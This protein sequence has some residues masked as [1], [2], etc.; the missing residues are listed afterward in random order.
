MCEEVFGS[1]ILKVY[2]FAGGANQMC[3]TQIR[4]VIMNAED[5]L[6]GFLE[7]IHYSF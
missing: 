7:A 5:D 1:V 6:V 3:N 2:D 4:C